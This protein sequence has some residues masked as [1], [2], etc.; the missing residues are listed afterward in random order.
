MRRHDWTGFAALAAMLA[1]PY[2]AF[3]LGA[4]AGLALSALAVLL[5]VLTRYF[6]LK[7][8]GPM[9][10]ILRWTLLLPRGNHTPEKLVRVL[11]PKR[12]ERI[13]EIGPGTGIHAVRVAAAL[14][15]GG[16]VDAIDVQQ[17]MLNDVMR[18][19]N[20][21]RLENVH[22]RRAS[23]SRIP[24][25]DHTFDAAYLI[26]VLGELRNGAAAMRELRRVLKPN[27]RL[28][29]GEVLFDPDYVRLS[30]LKKR[31]GAAGFRFDKKLGGSVSYLARFRSPPRERGTATVLAPID[32]EAEPAA[33]TG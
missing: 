30:A 12:G 13:L 8:P 26:G 28:V 24:F 11:R 15:P 31:A 5:L 6:S 2:A 20:E 7:Y 16:S 4:V 33:A 25:P 17:A 18:R 3:R 14:E 32:E 22:V 29:I 19:A 23:A 27:A 21:A 1:A 10:H 9:P